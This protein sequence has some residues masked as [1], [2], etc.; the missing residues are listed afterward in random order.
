MNAYTS[1]AQLYDELMRDN[2][3]GHWEEYLIGLFSYYEHTPNLMLDLGC[4]TGNMT[5]RMARRGIEMIGIDF[6][7]DML[8]MGKEKAGNEG[9]DILFLQQDMR[10]FELYG[11]VDTILSLC[12]SL[13]YILEEEE[14]FKVFQ[15]VN[16]YLD[17]EGLFIFDLNTEYKYHQILGE[18]TFAETLENSAYIWE[19]F[20]DIESKINEYLVTF[21]QKQNN[22][23]YKRF[24]EAHYQKAY[25]VPSV[26]ALLEKA[27]LKVL[28]VFHDYSFKKP[29]DHSERVVFVAQEKGKGI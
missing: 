10:D 22:G 11:T 25:S 28:N 15:L 5:I 6:S 12:D 1:F 8:G 3:Y 19:N 4:G 29:Q 17:P 24:E 7:E 9:V 26:T 20:F 21:F 27:G 23:L 18:Q 16:N 14:L 13:N 2:P